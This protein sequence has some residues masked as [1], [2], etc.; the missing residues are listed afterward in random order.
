MWNAFLVWYES[1]D[2]KRTRI[3]HDCGL[4]SRDG[5]WEG[6]SMS[7]TIEADLTSLF[8]V[9]HLFISLHLIIIVM[10]HHLW[11]TR[12]ALR[13]FPGVMT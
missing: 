6:E 7:A 8:G 1:Q 10:T 13:I 3:T 11:I 5:Q 2:P 9:A 12:G 4:L